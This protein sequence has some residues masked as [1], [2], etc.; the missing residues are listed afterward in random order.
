MSVLLS[1]GYSVGYK[2]MSTAKFCKSIVVVL[3]LHFDRV[4]ISKLR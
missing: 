3:N 1:C 4:L 2:Y